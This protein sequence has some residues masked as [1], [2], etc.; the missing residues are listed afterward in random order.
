MSNSIELLMDPKTNLVIGF[1]VEG[2]DEFL[3]DEIS[4]VFEREFI[5]SKREGEF[6]FIDNLFWQDITAEYRFASEELEG[7]ADLSIVVAEEKIRSKEAISALCEIDDIRAG[8]LA[9]Y[10]YEG[11]DMRCEECSSAITVEEITAHLSTI[12]QGCLN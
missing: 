9:H 6:F 2:I 7:L 12:C 10:I 3:L 1:N 11:W 5:C 4:R 8:Q